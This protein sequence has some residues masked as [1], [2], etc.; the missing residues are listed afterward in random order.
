MRLA[1]HSVALPQ[2]PRWVDRQLPVLVDLFQQLAQ[3]H[4]RLQTREPRLAHLA[5]AS[6][7]K[8]GLRKSLASMSPTAHQSRS[9]PTKRTGTNASD[10]KWKTVSS[11]EFSTLTSKM[12]IAHCIIDKVIPNDPS[13]GLY[14][15]F[16]G[17]GGRQVS[18]YCAERFPLEIKKELQKNPADLT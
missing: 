7:L 16:D 3:Q 1:H 12:S 5:L 4:N 10:H 18:D 17:H 15:I 8:A 14:A 11:I 2:A 9:T 13:T 6:V